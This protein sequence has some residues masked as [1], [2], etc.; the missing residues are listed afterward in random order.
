MYDSD[1]FIFKKW[2]VTS[3]NFV[4][5]NG[6]AIQYQHSSVNFDLCMNFVSSYKVVSYTA[7]FTHY[8]PCWKYSF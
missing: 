8:F 4:Q 1:K 5:I 6:Y 3:R 2:N 7:N